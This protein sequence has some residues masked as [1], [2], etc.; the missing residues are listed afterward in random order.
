MSTLDRK[1]ARHIIEQLGATGQPPEVG[2]QYFSVGLEPYLQ[3]IEEEYL[4]SFIQ[5]GGSSFKLVVGIY[6]G[7]KTHFLY[8]VRNLGWRQ[9]FAVS[10]VSLKAGGECPFDKLDL[11]Y[12]AIINGLLPPINNSDRRVDDIKGIENFLRHWYTQRIDHYRTAGKSPAAAKEAIEGDIESIAAGT[13]HSISFRNAIVKA[14]QALRQDDE[15]TYVLLCQWLKGEAPPSQALKRKQISQKVDRTTAFSFIRSLGQTMRL[16]GYSGLLVLLDEAERVPSMGRSQ[17]E[18]LL[19][20]L[21]EFIDECGHSSFQGMMVFYA[22]PDRGF[23]DGRTQVYQALNQRL[24]TIFDVVNPSGVCVELDEAI[25][26]PKTFLSD[27]GAKITPIYVTAYGASLDS[28]ATSQL[29]DSLADAVVRQRFADAGYKRMFVQRFVRG[30]NVL[31]REARIPTMEE[32][33]V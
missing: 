19:S 32:L 13:M 33:Q 3:V 17:R 30:L 8:C 24:E 7:G 31:N 23:L 6:G 14:L 15:S 10:Y 16:L 1:T 21:R 20:N 29:I 5:E 27:V 4:S 18:Q 9:N 22:V 2:V 12:R 11:V 28:A 25:Q 26:A